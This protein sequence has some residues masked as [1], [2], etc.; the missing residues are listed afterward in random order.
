MCNEPEKN[1]SEGGGEEKQR[2]QGERKDE[3]RKTAMVALLVFIMGIL[4]FRSPKK[5][6]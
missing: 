3:K 2:G 6:G 4:S 1:I 5:D